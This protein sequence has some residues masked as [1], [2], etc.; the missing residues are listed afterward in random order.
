MK[1]HLSKLLILGWLATIGQGMA[2]SNAPTNLS[3]TAPAYNQVVLTWKDNSTGETKFEIERNNFASFTKIGEAPANATTYTDNTVGGGTYRV[4]A[5]LATGVPTGYSNEFTIAT[6][7]EPPTVPTSLAATAS[8]ATSI[9]L[10]WTNP[11]AGTAT[12]FLLERGTSPGG[13]FTQIAV[14]PYSRTPTYDDTGALSGTQYCYRVRARG[15]GGTS[16]FSNTA[17][18]TTPALP[19]VP[20]TTPSGLNVLVISASQLQLFW[21]DI[22]TQVI[23]FEISR[24]DKPGGSY[25]VIQADY[26]QKIF[27]DKGLPA[28][29]PYCYKVRAKNSAGLYSGYSNEACNTTKAAPVTAPNAPARLTITGVSNSQVDL[30]WVDGSDNET[31]FQVE[32]ADGPTA[33]FQKIQD[34]GPNTTT[35][36][37][38]TVQP[39]NP[40][41]YRVRAVNSAGSSGYTDPQCTTT[42]APP[43]GVPVNLQATAASPTQIDLTWMAPNAAAGDIYEVQRATAAGGSYQSLKNVPIG[44]NGTGLY[45]DTGL[46]P[47]TLYCYRVRRYSAP[48][49]DPGNEACAT[50]QPPVPTVPRPPTLL[51]ATAVAASEID[52]TWTDGSDNETGFEIEGSTDGNTW[53]KLASVPAN[54]TTYQH[55]GLTPV[56]R[57]YYRVRAV[58]TV[59]PSTYANVANAITPDVP[60]VAPASLAATASSFSAI[61]LTWTNPATNATGIDIEQSL[62]GNAYKKI[63][64]VGATITTYIDTGLTPATRYYYRIRSVNPAGPSGYAGP[65]NA[66]TPDVSPA[67]PARL[68]AQAT[69]YSAVSLTWA[70]V[71]GNETGFEIEQSTDGITFN[72]VGTV[73]A[74]VT[75]YPQ[76]GLNGS[77]RY[78]Y[79]VR[80][81]NAIGPSGY[82]NVADVTT[83][84]A[85]LPAIP[86]N[87][88]A[89]PVDFD[90]IK[91]TWSPVSANTTTVVIE[92]STSATGGFV[93]IGQQVPAKTEFGDVGVLP[94][95]TYYYRIKARNLAGSSDY[96]NIA[97]VDASALIDGVEPALTTLSVYAA[98]HTLFVKADRR[99]DVAIRLFT[100]S[101]VAVFDKK[102]TL[103]AD[104][105]SRHS[106]Q[107]LPAGV[108]IATV[109]T[110]ESVFTK[111]IMLP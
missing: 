94:I 65:V 36:S 50:T 21:T 22:N 38:K 99:T 33:S 37:D 83:P 32:R 78:Y 88:T 2:Q 6:P 44:A 14:V 11:G 85:P 12:D 110:A 61:V 29:T 96:S 111:K 54:T 51:T 1:P 97:K 75:S 48:Q 30:Q 16:T 62:D 28:A 79:R 56:M 9:H 43:P 25:Q 42:L 52:L 91:L 109:Q 101:G 34:L 18:A 74:N 100:V 108:Y 47:N 73:N 66:L 69:S 76:T 103:D 20:P 15:A 80:A 13:S 49:S 27:D 81:V 107:E 17:C 95:A 4:R 53:T 87:L 58:N 59:G 31:G 3:G 24:A 40:Y 5:I 19:P 41:C 98:D 46:T 55:T 68:V 90:L 105:T 77:S 60:P 35:F 102:A 8:S 84:P 63:G 23:S 82:S 64:S 7:P 45:S 67:S 104:S 89:I 70:D 39:S 86:T 93:E 10:T 26:T 72:R 57:Y 71:S 106:L 92:R